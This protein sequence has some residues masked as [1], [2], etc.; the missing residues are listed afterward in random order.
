[1][2]LLEVAIPSLVGFIVAIISTLWI[3]K[4]SSD[5]GLV[6]K[7][8]NKPNKPEVPLLGGV[9]TVSGFVAGSFTLLALN[10]SLAPLVEPILLSSLIV[11]FLGVLDDLLNIR[12]SLR[13]FTPIFAAVP[14][15]LASLGHSTI[16]VPFLGPVNFGIFYY[17]LIVPIAL[18]ITSNAFNMLEGLNGLSA[19]MGIVMAAAFAFIGLRGS[20]YPFV[21]GLLSLI[22]ISCLL[23]FLVFNRYPARVFPGNVG[24][25]FIGALLGALGISGYMLTALVILYIPYVVEF[26][27]KARTRFKGISFG[28]PQQ[29]GTLVWSGKP[30]SLTHVVMKVG[31]LKEP[32]VVGL[33]WVMEALFAVLAVV[34]QTTVIIIR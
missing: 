28:I 16:S 6:G 14:V 23:G 30:Q 9:A 29:D 19:G 27:L 12:Q 5:R 22:L 13:A 25:Y 31:R 21:A 15:A 2:N 8:V 26:L 18:T 34:L 11:G 3:I 4:T 24:T 1:V 10:F 17:V 20:G 7:D 32:Q 33:L